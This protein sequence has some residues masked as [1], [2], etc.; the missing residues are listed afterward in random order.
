[1]L[2]AGPNS[3]GLVNPLQPLVATFSPV[4]HDPTAEPLCRQSSRPADRGQLPERRPDLRVS[5]PRPRPPTALHLSGQRRQPDRA[6][7]RTTTSIGC[8]MPAAPTSSL[9]SR[10]H[11]RPGALP[12]RRRQGGGRR[13]AAD[14]RQGRPLRRRP[15]RRRLAYRLA[16]RMP[17]PLDDAIFRHHGIIRG[18][19]LD[20]MVDVAAAF[21]YCKLPRGNRVAVITGSGGSAV[22]MADILSAHGLELAGAGRRHPAP[23]HGAPAVLRLGAEPGR[24]HRAGDRRS[25]LRPA[26]RARARSRERI[27]TILLISSLANEATAKNR[28][29]ELAAITGATEQA[30]PAVDLYDRDRRARSPPSPPPAS[31]ATPRCR[32]APARSARW[33][34]TRRFQARRHRA[35]RRPRPP[36]A[37]ARRDRGARSPAPGRC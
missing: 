2:I 34:I 23:H 1:M 20:H 33:S 35:G 37:I 7:K 14:R 22:W 25:R 32:A 16:R 31:P 29:E 9:L 15:P 24:R 30:D 26:R 4:F 8:S 21:A 5:E 10:R 27:D 3:E 36:P 17:A 18:E 11:P 13:Q 19:D 28:A 6:S 12:R